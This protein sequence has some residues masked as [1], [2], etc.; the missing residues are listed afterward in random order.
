MCRAAAQRLEPQ[1]LQATCRRRE[2][3]VTRTLLWQEHCDEAEAQRRT[4]CSRS[5][6]YSRLKALTRGP[7]GD[8]GMHFDYEPGGIPCSD[9]SGKTRDGERLAD[10]R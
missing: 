4:A 9:F 10:L 5:Q 1:A 6:F 8:A 2:P 3:R 7:A